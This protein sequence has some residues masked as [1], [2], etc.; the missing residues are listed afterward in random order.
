METG[1][2]T[3]KEK[4]TFS[5]YSESVDNL[6]GM[7]RINRSKGWKTRSKTFLNNSNNKNENETVPTTNSDLEQQHQSDTKTTPLNVTLGD[8]LACSGCITSAEAVLIAEQ[9]HEKVFKVLDQKLKDPSSNDLVIVLSLSLQSIASLA[10]K[11]QL[12]MQLTAERLAYFFHS[13]GV[14]HVLDIALARHLSLV[15]SAREFVNNQQQGQLSH[16]STILSSTCPGF[17]CY[18]EKS[19]GS[20]LLPLLSQVKSPQQIMGLLV[21]KRF[22]LLIPQEQQKSN[23]NNKKKKIYHI[24]L[25]P[26]YDKKLEASRL[27]N[28]ILIDQDDHVPEVDCVITPIEVEKM[29]VM[30]GY[31]KGLNSLEGRRN[32]D[33]FYPEFY[34]NENDS[35]SI[36]KL[37]SHPGSGSGGY[38]ENLFRFIAVELYSKKKLKNIEKSQELLPKV[39]TWKSIRNAD[40]LELKLYDHQNCNDVITTESDDSVDSPLLSFAIVNGFRNIQN[41]VS[42]VKRKTCSYDYVEVSACPKG[43]LNG[44]AQL[45]YSNEFNNDDVIGTTSTKTS[46]QLSSTVDPASFAFD[47]AQ[48]LYAQLPIEPD[49]SLEIPNFKLFDELDQKFMDQIDCQNTVLYRELKID[50][51]LCDQMRTKFQSVKKTFNILNSNW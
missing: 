25:M 51:S 28:R 40:F 14:D 48:K 2:K 11:Y 12:S 37:R 29:L 26:C 16:K 44:G 50:Q 34:K 17:V 10:G 27:D 45:R 8:C 30:K 47:R 6:D 19:Q 20:I 5:K 33:H 18:A 35:L 49:F 22:D 41:L 38:A 13:L 24:T 39:L 46:L 36:V 32:L 3:E 15:E 4:E 31:I 42:R 43:C 21:K 9:S 23:N 1:K 7:I